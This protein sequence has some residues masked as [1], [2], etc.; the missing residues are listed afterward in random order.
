MFD[1]SSASHFP[2]SVLHP[3]CQSSAD[4]P[5][6]MRR[7]DLHAFTWSPSAASRCGIHAAQKNLSPSP[8]KPCAPIENFFV[9]K[10]PPLVIGWPLKYM[11]RYP[12]SLNR[13]SSIQG[14]IA[15]MI[16]SFPPQAPFV[17]PPL[18]KP[19][20]PLSNPLKKWQKF[21]PK[22][23]VFL[24]KMLVSRSQ[25]LEK[26]NFQRVKPEKKFGKCQK[27]RKNEHFSRPANTKY[28]GKICPSAKKS[29][30]SPQKRNSLRPCPK[31]GN[32]KN[33]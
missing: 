29:P 17:F 14:P 30:T 10:R 25:T 31:Y 19:Q 24:E 13:A 20:S 33:R 26:P 9:E 21:P 4:F 18:P 27:S 5:N 1:N 6:P 16:R 2:V 32:F 12:K 7:N 23:L 15:G 3:R 8:A 28:P 11:P 22:N